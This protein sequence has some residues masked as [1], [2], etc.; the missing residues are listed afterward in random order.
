MVLLPGGRRSAF[1]FIRALLRG[2]V[3][4]AGFAGRP[5]ERIGAAWIE[6]DRRHAVPLTLDGEPCRLKP[7]VRFSLEKKRLRV[8][9]APR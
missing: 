6:I 9:A 4:D 2:G 5:I 8:I 1:S 3:R 7:P